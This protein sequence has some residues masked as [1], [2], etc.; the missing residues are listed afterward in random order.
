MIT[1][2]PQSMIQAI[3][4]IWLGVEWARLPETFE[5]YTEDGYH[6]FK[7]TNVTFE[8]CEEIQKWLKEHDNRYPIIDRGVVEIGFYDSSLATLFALTF[9]G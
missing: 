4:D 2:L 6:C 3:H 1:T 9:K 8:R 7:L 5:H